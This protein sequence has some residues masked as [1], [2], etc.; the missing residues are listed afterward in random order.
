ML[1]EQ[2]RHIYLLDLLIGHTAKAIDTVLHKGAIGEMYNIHWD[3]A[4]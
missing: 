4:L 1:L 3:G 2:Y